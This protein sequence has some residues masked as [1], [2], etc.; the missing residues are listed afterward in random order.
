MLTFASAPATADIVNVQSVISVEAK[1]GPSGSVTGALDYRR[2]NTER[3]VASLSPTLRY[4]IGPHLF[5]TYGTGEYSRNDNIK[6]IFGHGRYRYQLTSRLTGEFFTQLEANPRRAL[7]RR[8]LAGVG[9]LVKIAEGHGLRLSGAVAY[10]LEYED[11]DDLALSSTEEEDPGLQHR[12]SSYLTGSYQLADNLQ[13]VETIYVQPLITDPNDVRLLNE[14]QLSVAITSYLA[15][16]ASFT[17][18][19]DTEPN[20]IRENTEGKRLNLQL[21]NSLTLQF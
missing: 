20:P 18:S 17:L 6:T 19:Y 12:I 15:F 5:I 13:L 7:D 21:K 9:P 4:R 10:M 14:S 1:E 11:I 8:A 3:F 2:G 16:N